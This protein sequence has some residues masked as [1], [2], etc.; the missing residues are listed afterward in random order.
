M[1]CPRCEHDLEAVNQADMVVDTCRSGCGGIW[2]DAFELEKMDQPD[3]S[4]GWLLEEMPVDLSVAVDLEKRIDCPKCEGV[5]LM[6]QPYPNDHNIAIDRC[7]SCNGVWLDFG[8]LY[9]IRRAGKPTADEQ[10]AKATAGEILRKL[11]GAK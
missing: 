6:R 2:F 4:A 10:K 9:A 1:K 3:E 7:P 8:E 5:K 11:L